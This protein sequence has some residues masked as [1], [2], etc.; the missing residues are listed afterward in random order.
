MLQRPVDVLAPADAHRLTELVAALPRSITV[1]MIEHDMAVAFG[2]ADRVSVLHQGRMLA[3][4]TP[5]DISADQRV[6]EAYLG[7]ADDA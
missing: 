6:L 2:L 4:G 5:D 1:V 3:E 7:K